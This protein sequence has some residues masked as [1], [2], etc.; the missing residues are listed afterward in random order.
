[1]RSA[2]V[3]IIYLTILLALASLILFSNLHQGNL[4]DWDESIYGQVAKEMVHTN[5]PLTLHYNNK[6]T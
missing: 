6:K 3:K 1:M 2:Y 5:D 4:N